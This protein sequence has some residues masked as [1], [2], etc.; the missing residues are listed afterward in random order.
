MNTSIDISPF[1]RGTLQGKQVPDAL[2]SNHFLVDERAMLDWMAYASQIGRA[3]DFHAIDGSVQGTWESYLLSDE[4]MLTARMAKTNRIREYDQFISF[5]KALKDSEQNNIPTSDNKTYLTSLFALGFEVVLLLEEWYNLAKQSFTVNTVATYLRNRIQ[6]DGSTVL[7][8]FYQ[9]YCAQQRKEKFE[10]PNQIYLLSKLSTIWNFKPYVELT[11]TKQTD[12]LADIQKAGQQ[13]FQL[14]AEINDWAL[15]SFQRTLQRKDMPPHIGLMVAFFDLFRTQQKAL[16]TITQRHLE[17]YYQSVLQTRKKPAEPDQTIITVELAKGVEKLVVTKGT[18][19]TGKTANG[20]SITLLAKE[21]TAVNAAKIVR[22]LTLNFPCADVNVGDSEMILGTVSKFDDTGNAPWPIFGGGLPTVNW[23][24]Q[25]TTVGWAFSCS[26]LLL[27]EGTRLLTIQFACYVPSLSNLAGIDFSSLFEIKLSARDGWHTATIDQVD[28]QA[29]GRLTFT[30]SLAPSDPPIVAYT[31]K[32]HGSGYETAWPVCA[33]TL[34]DR[35][36][37]YYSIVS[38]WRIHTVSISTD[39][40]GIRDFLIENESGKLPNSAPFIPFNEPM[41][42]S[43]LYVGGQE[44]FVKPLTQLDLTITWDKLPSGFEEYYSAYNTYYQ[45]KNAAKPQATPDVDPGSQTEALLLNQSFKAK[46]FE[47]DGDTWNPLSKTGNNRIDYCLFTEDTNSSDSAA[48]Q[49]WDLVKNAQKKISLQGPFRFN[50]QLAP[51]AG[52]SN[53]LR[54]G[55]FCLSLSSPAQGFG[56]VDYP[57]IVS[58]VT[59]DNSAALMH[60]ARRFSFKWPIKP[61]PAIPYVPKIK[62][63]TVDYQSKQTYPLDAT[64]TF[65]NWYHLHPLGVE[66]VLFQDELPQLLP[67]YAAQ[68]YAYWGIES[69]TCDSQLSILMNIQSKAKSIHQS[70]PGDYTFEYMSATG[71]R[72]L[73]VIAD[74]TQGFQR[75]GEI[76]LSIPSDIISSGSYLP[77]GCYWMRCGQTTYSNIQTVF[78]STQAVSLVRVEQEQSVQPIQAGSIPKL[79]TNLAGIK[80]IRQPLLVSGGRPIATDQQYFRSVASRLRHKRRAVTCSD[81]E[82]LLLDE[83]PSLYKVTAL[84]QGY[85]QPDSIGLVRV[86]VTPYTHLQQSDCINPIASQELMLQIFDFLKS[87]GL[88]FV[89]YEISNPDFIEL[90]VVCQVKFKQPNQEQALI[91]QLTEELNQFMS[92]WIIDNT[93]AHPATEALTGS[94]LYGFIQSRSYVQTIEEFSYYL[95]GA[96]DQT[97]AD[98]ITVPPSAFIIPDP[99]HSIYS[100]SPNA[101]MDED[102]GLRIGETFYINP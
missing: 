79:T 17:F 10:E 1:I 71:W 77:D 50:P 7:N 27:A 33:I 101:S 22:Y 18:A 88:P 9:L 11:D 55:F 76:R 94:S 42:G 85:A 37:Q 19:V 60:N 75:S 47:L 58:S 96:S 48:G 26:D 80:T 2:A 61:L 95:F 93:L 4:S 70:V 44:F 6:S 40:K 98:V 59:M 8:A 64:S 62:K 30:L 68:A 72:T 3:L 57:A 46:V 84:P 87:L 39:V 53:T 82:T 23:S 34:T 14:P 99:H 52:L 43:S 90:K 100:S 83:F 97:T 78:V 31:K 45:E 81:I 15:D 41:P 54:E 67:T 63:M 13:I 21:D 29:D 91:N 25:S 12:L 102:E 56:S 5:C 66:P 49:Q 16:N 65:I 86:L 20:E 38:T 73:L 32:I 74:G 92:P 89:Q 36:R 69:I 51:L 35:G 24:S 28:Y